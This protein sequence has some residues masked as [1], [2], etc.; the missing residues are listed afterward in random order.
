MNL[1]KHIFT[2]Q[3]SKNFNFTLVFLSL[4]FFLKIFSEFFWNFLLKCLKKDELNL[5]FFAGSSTFSEKTAE[6]FTEFSSEFGFL[7]LK[8]YLKVFPKKRKLRKR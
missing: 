1:I 6:Y 3:F 8:F 4:N 5:Q 2:Q 7:I